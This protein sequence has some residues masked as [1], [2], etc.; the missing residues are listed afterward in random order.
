MRKEKSKHY[1]DTLMG[2]LAFG[3]FA[4]CILSVLLS[5]AGVYRRL[6]ARDREVYER[7]SCA[8]YLSMKL[9]QAPSADAVSLFD[10]DGGSALRIKEDIDGREYFSYV[11]C[12]DGWLRELFAP[13]QDDF[14]PDAGEKLIE[15][16]SLSFTRQDG[17][18]SVLFTDASGS[19]SHIFLSLRGGEGAS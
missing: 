14:S 19:E 7:R 13:A 10:F 9:R 6:T 16:Q 18:L 15:L 1:I 12:A 11:Y 5:G 17:R 3:V 8:Q 4:G 2:L